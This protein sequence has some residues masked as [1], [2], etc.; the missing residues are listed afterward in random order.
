MDPA[1]VNGNVQ[2]RVDGADVG[3]PVTPGADG[4]ARLPHTF[5]TAGTRAG[6]RNVPGSQRIPEFQLDRGKGHG[7]LPHLSS[8]RPTLP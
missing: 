3:T 7:G 6:L 8:S 5:F 4:T 2:F 1:P